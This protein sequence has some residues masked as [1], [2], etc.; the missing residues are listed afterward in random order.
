MSLLTKLGA[1][2]AV[3]MLAACGSPEERS[4]ND[5]FNSTAAE[6]ENKAAQLDREA[7]NNVDAQTQALEEEA[8]A[9]RETTGDGN[10]TGNE[11]AAEPL[12][13]NR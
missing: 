7:A 9:L 8:R 13:N 1:G 11:A 2:C 10:S 12:L 6:L 4:F 5:Q 3:A